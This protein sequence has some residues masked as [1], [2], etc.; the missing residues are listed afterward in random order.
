MTTMPTPMCQGVNDL[1]CP[2]DKSGFP[3]EVNGKT[4]RLCRVCYAAV[5]PSEPDS[6]RITVNEEL[7]LTPARLTQGLDGSLPN[8]P[9]GDTVVEGS[10]PMFDTQEDLDTGI[11][12]ADHRRRSSRKTSDPRSGKVLVRNELL[13]YCFNMINVMA[14]SLLQKVCADFYDDD[15]IESARAELV[16]HI[17]DEEMRSKL[18]KKRRGSG[19]KNLVMKDILDG[20]RANEPDIFPVYVAKSLGSMPPL[21]KNSVNMASIM[22]ELAQLRSDV[23][24]IQV[25]DFQLS[26]L[27]D[28]IGELRQQLH[29]VTLGAQFPPVQRLTVTPLLPG[30]M[31]SDTS[32]RQHDREPPSPS[33]LF[34]ESP[35]NSATRNVSMPMG[36]RVDN[37]GLLGTIRPHNQME[38][39]VQ[40]PSS[41]DQPDPRPGPAAASPRQAPPPPVTRLLKETVRAESRDSTNRSHM[42][43]AQATVSGISSNAPRKRSRAP[44]TDGFVTVGPKG[45]KVRPAKSLVDRMSDDLNLKPERPRK[46][47]IIYVSNVNPNIDNDSMKAEV[48]RR[49]GIDVRCKRLNPYME[50]PDFVSFQIFARPDKAG[51]ILDKSKWPSWVI[52]RPW[53]KR[54]RK[55]NIR[56][57]SPPVD[58]SNPIETVIG[59]H[60]Y[61]SGTPQASYNECNDRDRDH[62]DYGTPVNWYDIN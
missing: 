31:G 55:G 58:M 27:T 18:L 12:G 37:S 10:Q 52:V 32:S 34:A 21:S 29:A 8:S 22:V 5:R 60:S 28:A 40:S 59:V 57:G 33:G 48:K 7:T 43:Y 35:A 20:V 1:P 13:C 45:R 6:V 38:G 36:A 30:G 46:S 50:D 19:R 41:A 14:Q 61:Q 39:I 16:S 4:M 53:E 23:N 26:S 49:F 42:N 9:A 17:T 56:T 3:I 25:R 54:G 24:A 47:E 11:D 15:T 51:L 44:D 2:G 62:S